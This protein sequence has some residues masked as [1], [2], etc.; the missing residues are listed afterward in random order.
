MSSLA[1]LQLVASR[2]EGKGEHESTASQGAAHGERRDAS[3]PSSKLD[4][5][6]RRRTLIYMYDDDVIM[7]YVRCIITYTLFVV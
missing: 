3:R 7:L 1:V 4:V 5:I 6:R 2:S